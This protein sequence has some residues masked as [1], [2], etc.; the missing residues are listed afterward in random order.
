MSR[1]AGTSMALLLPFSVATTAL[2]ETTA[3]IVMSDNRGITS[4]TRTV[5]N[6]KA[7]LE[8]G[9]MHTNGTG[10]YSTVSCETDGK[11]TYHSCLSTTPDNRG[12][13]TC[14]K[15]EP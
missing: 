3:T 13:P 9:Q 5:A 6:D 14:K 1:I 12:L 2:A 11:V 4:F 8:M 10:R 15:L 7:C